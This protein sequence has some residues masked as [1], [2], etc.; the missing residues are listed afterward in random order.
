M[1][2]STKTFGH[3]IGLS[4]AFRQWRADSHCKYL[5][6]YALAFKFIFGAE[7]LDARNWVVDF[8]GLKSLKAMLE[9]TFDHKTLVA[10]D[11]PHM[12]LFQQLAVHGIIQLVVVEST[13]CEATAKLVFDC[14]EQWL[15]DAGYNADRVA[16]LSVEVSEH[17]ANSA[18]YTRPDF[19]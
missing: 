12:D 4:C 19:D 11:D 10:Q 6:G 13:G 15:R 1:Y 18:I 14:A 2:Q 16:L 8:G 7:H 17:G 9:T 3:E 5:H